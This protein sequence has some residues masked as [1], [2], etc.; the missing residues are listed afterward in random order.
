M[1]KCSLG[2]LSLNTDFIIISFIIQLHLPLPPPPHGHQM[3]S[4]N[5]MKY[6]GVTITVYLRLI[7]MLKTLTDKANRCGG[8]LRRNLQINSTPRMYTN[9]TKHYYDH[10]LNMRHHCGTRTHIPTFKNL[11]CYNVDVESDITPRDNNG[12]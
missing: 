4:V 6:L 5:S 8:F 11:K 2:L 9:H 10:L 1:G 7:S 12:V 3:E